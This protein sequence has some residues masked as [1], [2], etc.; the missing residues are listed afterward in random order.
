MR[1]LSPLAA[2]SGVDDLKAELGRLTLAAWNSWARRLHFPEVS[3][4]CRYRC[5]RYGPQALSF[6]I[7]CPLRAID[8][9]P[10]AVLAFLDD[11]GQQQN[12]A[13]GDLSSRGCFQ[14]MG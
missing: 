5:Y 3:Q 13:K 11:C 14:R 12:V 2:R 6:S 1:T 10:T 9:W 4:S 8:F 7:E